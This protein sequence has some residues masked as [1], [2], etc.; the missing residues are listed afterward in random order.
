[1]EQYPTL[2]EQIESAGIHYPRSYDI[3]YRIGYVLQSIGACSFA[4]LYGFGLPF[5]LIPVVVFNAGIAV[6][7]LYLLVWMAQI[8]RFI[9]IMTFAG[10]AIQISSIFIAPIS[11][12]Y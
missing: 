10:I 9:L 3:V 5:K 12:F 7:S 4:I 8:K 2:E 1:M 6:S 11:V